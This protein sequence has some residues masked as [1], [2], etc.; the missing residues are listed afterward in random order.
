MGSLK[1]Y[2]VQIENVILLI[3]SPIVIMYGLGAMVTELWDW[4]FQ[5]DYSHPSIQFFLSYVFL[6]MLL[7]SAL[8]KVLLDFIRNLKR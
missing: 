5:I 4:P 7:Q 3:I 6:F 2:K 8:I 1:K